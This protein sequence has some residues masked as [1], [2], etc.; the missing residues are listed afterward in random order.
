MNPEQ[1]QVQLLELLDDIHARGR[2]GED[3]TDRD[4]HKLLHEIVKGFIDL[5]KEV[6]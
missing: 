3:L 1:L 4:I 5:L 6:N 2:R